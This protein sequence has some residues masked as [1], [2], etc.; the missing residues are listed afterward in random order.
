MD[1]I[2]DKLLQRRSKLSPTQRS[3][4]AKRLRGEVDSHSQLEVISRRS[5]TSPAPLSYAQQRLW[6]IHQLDPD[7]PHYSELACVQLTGALN[8]DAL[9]K[10]FNEIVQRHEALRTTFELVEEQAVQVIHSAVTIELPVVNLRWIPEVEQQAQIEQITTEIAQKPFDLATAPLLRAILLQI[11]EEEYLLL[12]IIHHIVVDGWSIGLLIRELA[13]LY[14]AFSTGKTSPLPDLPIQYAD[15]AIWQ[16]QWLQ[17]QLQKTQLD[18]WKQQLAGVTTLALPTDRPRPP[19][20]S[21]QGAVTSF[22]L[23]ASLT[24]MLRD[25]SNQEGVTLFMTVMAAFQALLYRYT[26]QEDICVGSPIANRNQSEIQGLIGFFVN[27]L[28]LRTHV[29]GNLSFLELLN[30]VR[31]VCVGAYA[32]ADLPFEQLVAEL[33]PDR[34]LSHMPLFQVMFAWQEDT[35]KELTLPGLT[36]NWLPTV[37]QTSRFDLTLH[38]VDAK[39]ELKGFLEYNTDL[40]DAETVSRII[41][42][43]RTLLEGIVANPQARLLDLPILTTNELN[44]QL[45]E[46][47]NTEVE[48]PQQQCIHEL[49]EAQVQKTPDAVAVVFEDKQLTYGELNARANQLAHYLQKL[50]VKPEV[51]VGICVERSLAMVIGLLA[52]L[53]AGAA[54]VPLDPSYPQERLAYILEDTQAS[55][56]L[57]QTSLLEVIPPHKAQVVCVDT[58]W[59]LIE[60]QSQENLFFQLTPD[61]LA[62]T[63]YTSGST[64]KPKGVQIAHIALSNFL[65]AMQQNP[66]ITTEDT[67][68]AVTTYSFDIAALELFLPIIVGGRLVI[69]SPEVA[70]DGTQLSATLTDSQATVMQ[71][72]P[73]TWQLLLAADWHGNQQLKILCGGEALPGYLAYQLQQ[74]CHSLWNMY[75]PTETT[76]WSAASLVKTVDNTVPISQPI[77]NTQLYILDQY[78]QLVPV[79]VAG[80]LCIGGEGLARGYFHRPDLTAEKFIPNP[81]SNKAATRLYK[82]GDLAR[83]L[84]N[85]E[86]EYIGRIDN[87]VK[88]RGFRIE[89]GEIEALIT[90]YPVVR[91]TVVVVR[92]DLADS[93]TLVAYV[94]PQQEQKLT[95]SELRSFLESKLPNYMVP[96]AV[97]TLEALPL[98][99]NGKID[100]KALPAPEL[101]QLSSSNY[102][103]PTTPIENLLVG[104]WAEILKL[105]RIGIHDNFFELGGHSLIATRVISQIRQ[106]FSRELPLRCLFEKPTIA[107]LATEIETAQKAGLGIETTKIERVER[108]S[109]LPLSFAQQRL[110]F[111]AQLEP[112][113]PFYNIPAAVRLQGELNFNALQQTFTEILHRHETL[114][115]NFQTMEGQAIT[116]INEATPLVLP[117]LDLSQLPLEQQELEVKQQAAQEAQQPFD[118]SSDYLLRVKL[119]R[120]NAQEHIVL[121]TMHHIVSDGW[122]IGV[123]VQELATLYPAF[124]HGQGSPLT[125]L[126][127]QYVDFA[128]WQRQWLQ[129]QV[130][131]SQISYWRQLLENSPKL[132][133]LPTDYPRPVIQTFRGATYSFNISEELSL[134]LRKLSQQQGSTLFMTL[135]AA[136]QTLLWRY[137]GQEDI[138]VGSPIAN[139]NRAEIEGLI[140]FFVNTLVLRTNLAGNPRFEELLKRVR[141]VALGAYA[142]QDLPF[143]LLVEQ[144]QPQRD[145]SYT[146]L[147]QVMF[148]LQNAPMSALELP[149]LT[150]SPVENESNTS[151]FDLTLYMSETESGIVGNLEYNTDLFQESSIHRMVEY[152]QTLLSGIV[153]NPQQRLSKLP[154]LSEPEKYQ[155]LQE[156]NDTQVEYPQEQCIHQLFEGQVQKTPDAV[157]V[158]FEDEQLTYCELNARA[159]QLAHYLRSLGVKPEVLVGI[160][161]ERSLDMVIGLL[162]ILKAGGAYIPLDPNYPQE[163]LAF[164]LKDAQVSVLLTQASLLATIPQHQAQTICIDTDW[165]FISPQNPENLFSQ[166]TPENLA[167]AIYTSGSTGKPK[168]VQIPHIAL[169]NFLFAMQQSPGITKEDTLLAVTTYSFDI[170]AL[171]LFLPIIVGAR[172]VIVSREV[173]ADGIQL[174]AKLMDF[175]ATLMQATPA[176]W[177]L[178]L[179]AGWSGNQQLKILCGGEALPAHLANQLLERCASV[180]NMYGPTETTIWSAASEVK[181]VNGTV[182]ISQPIAN[183]Q[184]YILDQYNQLVPVGVPGQLCIAGDGLARGYFQR[185]NLTAE[186]F[187]PHP[188]SDK[189]SA[190]LYLTGDL[191]RYLPNGEIEYL[192]RIDN[193]VKLRGFRIELGEIETV[194]IQHP[195]VRETVVTVADSQSLVAY[196]V[197]QTQQTLAI[198][199]LRGLLESQLPSYMIPGAFVILEALP[200]TPNGKVDRKALPAPEFTQILL[201]SQSPSTPIEILLAGIWTE[202]LGINHVG[203][204]DNFFELGGHSLIATRVMSQIRQVF[205]VELPLRRLFE[206]PTIA[207]LA[208]EIENAIQVGLGVERINIER[209]ARLPHLPLSFAQQRLWFL[210]QLEPDSPFYNIFAAVRL[211]GELNIQALQQT[212]NEILS[213]HEALRTNFKTVEGQAV[214]IIS[215]ATPLKLPQIDLSQLPANQQED[216]VKQQTLK[217]A[218]QPFDLTTDVLLRVKLLRLGQ[219]EHIA[220]LTMH[221]IAADGWSVGVL[222]QELATLYPAF[223]NGQ[224]SPLIELPIQYVDFAAWQRQWLQ[225]EILQSQISYWRSQLEDAPKVLEL[226]TDYPRPAIQT[227]QGATYSFELS[228]ELS[229]SLNKLSQQQGSTLFM[230]LLAAFQTLLW[231]YT[232]QEDIVVG[233]P[234]ANRHRSE[235]EGLI[236]CFVNTLVLR[237][238]LAGN[239]SFPELLKRVREVALGAYAHQ[240]LPFEHLVEQLQPERHLNRNP[241]FDVMFVLQNAPAQELKLPGLTLSLLSEE[242]QTA[243]LDLTLSMTET[244]QG[245]LGQMEYSTYLFDSST[246]ERMV[247]HF[248]VL[249]AAIVAEPEQCLSDLPLLSAAEQHQLLLEWNHTDAEYATDKCIHE[250]FEVQVERTPDAVAVVFDNQQLTYRELNTKANQLAHYLRSLGVKPEVLIGICV[251]RS[252]SQVIA[253]LGVLKAGGAYVPLDPTYPRDRLRGMVED[254]QVK[255]L[256]AQQQLI[257]ELPETNAYLVCLDR[258]WDLIAQQQPDNCASAVIPENLAYV[259]YTSGSTGKPKGAMVAHQALVNYS[260]EIAKQFNLQ[261]SDR[262]LQFASVGFDVVVEELFPTWL[263]GATVVLLESKQPISCAELLQLINKH[264]LTVFEL[265]TAYWH[266]WVYELSLRQAPL[267]ACV[268]L[269]II[270]G[271]TVSPQHLA[272]WQKFGSDLVHV[273]GLTETTVTSTL[274]H[275]PCGVY[276]QQINNGNLPIGRPIANTQIYILDEALQPV[277]VGVVGELYIG[278]VS[279]GRGYLKSGDITAQRFVPH[280]FSYKAGERLYKTGDLARYLAD[281]NIECLGRIDHQVKF[282]G[283]R[284]EVEEIEA[285]INQ[286]PA[287]CAS[288]VVLREDEP[289]NKTLVAYITLGAQQQLTSIE[290]RRFLEPNLPSY[291]LPT[292]IVMLDAL[293]VTPN[294]KVDRHA[295]PAPDLTQ[296]LQKSDFVPASTP[297]EQMLVSIWAEILGIDQLGIHDNFFDLGGHSLLA[298]QLISRIRQILHLDLPLRCLFEAPTIAEL[299]S[300]IQ[301]MVM[302]G[303]NWQN[304]P[305]I[306][307]C[308]R[309]VELPLSFAQNRLWFI[310]QL[311]PGNSAYNIFEA[312]RLKG[313]LNLTALEQ[314]INEIIRRHEILRTQFIAVDGQPVQVII[315]DLQLNLPLIDLEILSATA[316][317]AEVQRLITQAAQQPFDLTQAPLV[318][319]S[320]VKLNT[321]EHI[322]LFAMHHIIFDAWSMEILV[323]EVATLYSLFCGGKSSLS[324]GSPL[325]ELPIQYADFAVWQRQWL[326]GEVLQTQLN[327]WKKQLG[328]TFPR[329]NLPQKYLRSSIVNN[330]GANQSFTLSPELTEAINLLNRQ[331]G[332]TLFMTLLAVFQVLLYCFTG[333]EDIRVGSPI[334]NRNRVEIEKLIGFFVNTLVLRI[335]LSGNPS[336]S[337]L[338]VRSR[339]IT[340]EAY[341]HQDLPFEKLVEQLQPER[342]LNHNPLYQAWFVLQN[343]P[344]Q[345]LELPGLTLTSFAMENN[346]TKHDLLLEIAESS[347]GLNGNFAYKIHL[348]NHLSVSRLIRHFE[349]LL[350]SVTARPDTKLNELVKIL[351]EMEQEQQEIQKQELQAVQQQKL[352]M[353]KRKKN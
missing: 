99:P 349:K 248:Q 83:Y 341:A 299:A 191:A 208:K 236:G 337:E 28:V 142:H 261:Q 319:G 270:G 252:P 70:S 247:G 166:I 82:T 291:M 123:L 336:F 144:L 241:L 117:L 322:V 282:R 98:T 49:F 81:F 20:Q 128:A 120:L 352:K 152:L 171:E 257:A 17:G 71:A 56:L 329:L 31:E 258:D 6:F 33:Q 328:N 231:R 210:A 229:V 156:W 110:W 176:T 32:H 73:A 332:V 21:F 212:F 242:N 154:L 149:D 185:P 18:Y 61:N 76:I 165:H 204:G 159:N 45:L 29:A 87:Q 233:S 93:Q 1:N 318:R 5:Q 268:R 48:Y 260:L 89:L 129:A 279:L 63:I 326:Q 195:A 178:L 177:Q 193:Q 182:K 51:L 140:G 277:P 265:P 313:S 317:E 246:I 125:E 263:S 150:L 228:K 287:V 10:S 245:L 62:Y 78:H 2:K 273:Y 67:L 161:V 175:Q 213:R 26:G 321:T 218:Q 127:I 224:L 12:F 301:T 157:A 103:P 304:S 69:T 160:C 85:G 340:L 109:Q 312:I 68:L 135:L 9:E 338:L 343:T 151:K 292:A 136:F 283:F 53:K 284:I 95:I 122:S 162:A 310:D 285:A 25:L 72:T 315:P 111:L 90:Q 189:P 134:A 234:I 34:N 44:Q 4:L 38:V 219:Q 244:E 249:L 184:L 14:E 272:A 217:E 24:N 106:V 121:L 288:V 118:I 187:I 80:E 235:I 3:L 36:L 148:V 97:V 54:Y 66:G 238:N 203:V 199:E 320:L 164:I 113:S 23:S 281:G 139:R 30:R 40:F 342:N 345:Q 330:Q 192:G 52:I 227:F 143:E 346:T 251:E 274:Y 196:V 206:K 276:T 167:Y 74:R 289:G 294:G 50:G 221:H 308:S 353:S 79:G 302:Q 250:L 55:V 37:T 19:I 194:I 75:G 112:D 256:L 335:D 259:I 186:K 8:V 11:G 325:P 41:A 271:E 130:L 92:S 183:T 39:P 334:A 311:Q 243:I 264:Q 108:T 105:D 303:Q 331:A 316:Q 347:A 169:S 180:W 91:E 266:Q 216:Q 168:G 181:T 211:Q 119:L 141:E 214:I 237:T 201:S 158:V 47:N 174:S 230:T 333:T 267:P 116:I 146:P 344:M 209:I 147:F 7:N 262:I 286:H 220:L 215:E 104:I 197:P 102:V 138:V 314:S 226:P 278:G 170:A 254:A 179:A 173:A 115:T 293:P 64:G 15:F 77:A 137:T 133:E 35:E 96:A 58:D 190:R 309:Q 60:Q 269:T 42:H 307:P 348:F 305:S 86:I 153:V 59:H 101:I 295:L 324:P 255:V 46:W 350:V 107:G 225:G 232:G 43:L 327:Y 323:E 200:L 339:R 132:L 240:D 114:R 198:T 306:L 222:V 298:T 57:T 300:V 239:P 202:V 88:I 13:L 205:S 145:L 290:L 84:P 351:A 280:P 65:L 131:E 253:I 297:L 94:V 124:C 296:L 100:R 172:L 27:T 275:L 126:P 16:R 223:C 155:L 207:G 188:F 163:R 22:E